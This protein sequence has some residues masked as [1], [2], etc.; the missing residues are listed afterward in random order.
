LDQLFPRT[1][2]ALSVHCPH[3]ERIEQRCEDYTV[4]P[5]RGVRPAIN[6]LNTLLQTCSNFKAFTNLKVQIDAEEILRGPWANPG[7]EILP[8]QVSGCGRLTRDEKMLYKSI[9][10]AAKLH[11]QEE[12]KEEEKDD[13]LSEEER[14]VV[15]KLQR[16][17]DTQIQVCERLGSLM[18]LRE[19]DLGHR[20][21]DME[22]I[23]SFQ[24]IGNYGKPVYLREGPFIR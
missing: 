2:K 12:E 5:E 6:S 23:N 15:R 24:Y 10:T 21:N 9:S 22:D 13:R 11:S 7:I 3:L 4:Y 19:L 17:R 18:Q 20:Y 8:L 16:S 14:R 1:A